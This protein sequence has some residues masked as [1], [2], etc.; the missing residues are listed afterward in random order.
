MPFY[1]RLGKLPAKR[2]S[3][4][5]QK[6]G[7]LHPEE[8]VG[9]H[10]FTGPATLLYH[11]HAPT[12][13]RAIRHL[14][15]VA[16]IADP[17]PTFRHRHFKTAKL[18]AAASPTLD[19]QPLLFN[20]EVAMSF[21]RATRPDEFFYRNGQA[22][23]LV[24]LSEGGG[25]LE[26][27]MGT[28]EVRKGDYV[29]IPRGIL[30]RF[31]FEGE[32][33]CLVMES[34]GSIRTPKRYRNEFGQLLE[35]SPYS[36]RDLRPPSELPVHD[37]QGDHRLVIKKGDKLQEV[38]LDH[39]PFDVVGWDG[40]Y[41]PFAFNIG[42]FEPRVGRFHLPPPVHQTFEGD[43]FVVCSFCP[44]P[45]DFDAQGVPAPY[46][47][48]NVMSD[49]VLYYANSEFMSRKGIEY[50]SITL[51]PD[52]IPHGP[53]PGRTEE[54]LGKPKTSELAV[55]MDTFRPLQ[56]AQPALAIEDAGYYRSWIEEGGNH[57]L[58]GGL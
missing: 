6:D 26:S 37:Q 11:V 43:G 22:D 19:R 32:L 48:S 21:V 33:R 47:H 50:G 2:H 7:S 44:R 3:I 41:F 57:P 20:H 9:N 56:V 34:A 51:H 10:G 58:T 45:F 1:H 38:V 25:T 27:Q 23:E 42:D 53:H 55:M 4:F 28:L 5:R 35:H 17:E 13:V 36:E 15:D 14:R 8:L 18:A 31:V 30:H 16:L 24:Y 40:Y 12:R 54:S 46:N 52:G 39:H 29:V 49:E